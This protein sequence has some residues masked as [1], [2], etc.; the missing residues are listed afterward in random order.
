MRR[1]AEDAFW[2]SF[3]DT[4]QFRLFHRHILTKM[5]NVIDLT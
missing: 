1:V 4:S 2:I 3:S 5:E